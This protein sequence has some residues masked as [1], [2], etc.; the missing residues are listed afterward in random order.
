MAKDLDKSLTELAET[1]WTTGAGA[2]FQLMV[3]T[4]WADN[5]E[6]YARLLETLQTALKESAREYDNLS[7]QIEQIKIR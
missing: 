3:Q 4:N 6:K 2:A 5:I 7:N 1:S